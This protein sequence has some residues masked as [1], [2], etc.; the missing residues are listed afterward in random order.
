MSHFK[1]TDAQ[2]VK[3][4]AVSEFHFTLCI[5]H[6]DYWHMETVSSVNMGSYY[7]VGNCGYTLQMC[8]SIH[9]NEN[10]SQV[11]RKHMPTRSTSFGA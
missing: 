9:G 1:H 11:E 2:S 3:N 10:N 5:M 6:P 4:G 7:T 8:M